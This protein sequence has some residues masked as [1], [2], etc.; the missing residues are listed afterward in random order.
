ME[1]DFSALYGI[2]NIRLVE[3]DKITHIKYFGEVFYSKIDK[4]KNILIIKTSIN[5]FNPD[6][7]EGC[8]IEIDF[9]MMKW[10][11]SKYQKTKIFF[12]MNLIKVGFKV[13]IDSIGE[14]YYVFS[15]ANYEDV[16]DEIL[17]IQDVT[18]IG[19][20]FKSLINER[21]ELMERLKEARLSNNHE[22]YRDILKSIHEINKCIYMNFES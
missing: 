9:N 11:N 18:L 17:W 1:N 8:Y 13:E 2:N 22:E 21:E 3:S 10:D 4:N 5:E 15:D 19:V 7:I 16:K 6:K 20:V 14:I 12:D